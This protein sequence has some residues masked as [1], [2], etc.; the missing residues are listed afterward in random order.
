MEKSGYGDAT[1][2]GDRRSMGV[3]R[4][5]FEEY[6]CLYILRLYIETM[7]TTLQAWGNSQ[8]VRIPKALL[9]ALHLKT[10][11]RLQ[12][13]LSQ[14]GDAI[15]VKPASDSIPVR[16]RHKIEDLM[17]DMPRDYKTNEFF[18]QASGNEV[19]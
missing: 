4:I 17:A 13:K 11:A 18:E 9:T 5:F 1:E 6:Y 8:G 7:T 16:G 12:V 19:W 3:W 15:I 2:K 10:G 14:K